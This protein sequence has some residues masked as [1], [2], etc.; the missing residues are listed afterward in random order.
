MTNICVCV[1]VYVG[2][3]VSPFT[4]C[5]C[6]A[7]R[8]QLRSVSPNI[9]SYNAAIASCEEV[10]MVS[11]SHRCSVQWMGWFLLKNGILQQWKAY[12]GIV[13]YWGIHLGVGWTPLDASGCVLQLKKSSCLRRITTK[14]DPFLAPTVLHEPIS[15][16]LMN[17]CLHIRPLSFAGDVSIYIIIDDRISIDGRRTK[18]RFWV[19]CFIGFITQMLH[20]WNSYQ[21]LP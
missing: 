15:T 8:H 13:C 18:H 17:M 3:C 9:I 11:L 19:A 20:V 21:Y 14:H 2:M 12:D 16:P 10:S 5:P 1:C 6:R 7:S 4:D